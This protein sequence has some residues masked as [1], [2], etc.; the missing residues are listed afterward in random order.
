VPFEAIAMRPGANYRVKRFMP[1]EG[2][3]VV[4]GPPKCGKSFFVS[5]VALHV[6]L[7]WPYR[8]RRVQQ[9]RVVYVCLEGEI[10]FSA[11]IE[12]FRQ[13]RLG[14]EAEDVPFFLLTTRLDL[15][16]EASLLAKEIEDQIG[17]A[18]CAMIVIDTLNRSLNG[19][20]SA[21]Q[22]MATY[23]KGADLLREKFRGTVVIVHH[24]G[25]DATRMRGHSSLLG[26]A[27]AVIAVKRDAADRIVAN[28][29]YMK[30]GPSGEEI[31]S[32]LKVIEL[33]EDEDGDAITSCVVE[34]AEGEVGLH[35]PSDGKLS[36]QHKLALDMLRR[37][38]DEA[39][40]IPPA[41]QHIPTGYR[42]VKL[43]TWRRY[44]YAGSLTE[45]HNAD[46]RKK[47][48]K[49]SSE[50]LIR[51]GLIASW[52]GWVWLTSLK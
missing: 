4:W 46:A 31:V 42:A 32:A 16:A 14:E 19:S 41:N 50:R 45:A 51:L 9:G 24:C 30:D 1:R 22:D 34:P 25:H 49:R 8:G 7:G 26:A 11:R 13:G 18:G 17:A 47:A 36:D 38:I 35:A 21:D 20:E 48:F 28:L 23:I 43:E 5:D 2:L 33:G 40:E 6:A 15:A 29:E 37:A 3:V 52:E 39:A 44:A 12:A 10:G 27:D